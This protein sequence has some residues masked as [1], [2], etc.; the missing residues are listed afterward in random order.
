MCIDGVEITIV[1]RFIL[2][3]DKWKSNLFYMIVISFVE[4]SEVKIQDLM[5]L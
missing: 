5:K 4:N 2:L 3:V 1:H